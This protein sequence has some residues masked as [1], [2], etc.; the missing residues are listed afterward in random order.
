MNFA[1]LKK[2]ATEKLNNEGYDSMLLVSLPDPI[3][4]KD[5]DNSM[6]YGIA[7]G[8]ILMPLCL[9]PYIKQA[10][11]EKSR[12]EFVDWLASHGA[13]INFSFFNTPER[14]TIRWVKKH[15]KM[16]QNAGAFL[17][18]DNDLLMLGM[19]LDPEHEFMMTPENF[20]ELYERIE[21]ALQAY[22]DGEISLNLD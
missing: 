13:R 20:P 16:A 22:L 14:Y 12:P 15:Q 19:A 17:S 21:E 4:T 8:G 2:A 1:E 3:R 9:R 11:E 7:Y 18:D 5:P 10:N 6:N